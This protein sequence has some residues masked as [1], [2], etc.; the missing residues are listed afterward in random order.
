MRAMG[1]KGRG[2]A[3]DLMLGVLQCPPCRSDLV[4]RQGCIGGQ[5]TAHS[6]LSHN[7]MKRARVGFLFI[8]FFT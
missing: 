5:M 1:E 7:H 4:K 2:A 3:T 8:Y 6:M